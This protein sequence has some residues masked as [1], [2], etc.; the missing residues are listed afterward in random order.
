MPGKAFRLNQKVFFL[1][2]HGLKRYLGPVPHDLSYYSKCM[3]GGALACGLTH[4]GITPLDVAKCN[5]QASHFHNPG[6]HTDDVLFVRS[7]PRNT[8]VSAPL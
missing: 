1:F 2:A 7:P 5:M 3:L 6:T 8:R 4:A